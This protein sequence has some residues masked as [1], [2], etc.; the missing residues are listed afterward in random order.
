MVQKPRVLVIEDDE[1]IREILVDLLQ[2][3][4]YQSTGAVHGRD[5]LDK[6]R[7]MSARPKLI[8]LDLM[9]PIMD[10]RE[11][12]EK[13]LA[14]P[15]LADIPVVIISAFRDGER[16]FEALKP[17]AFVPKPIDLQ[18]LLQIVESFAKAG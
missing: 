18:R 13:Q 3:Y 4:G 1:D 14:T 10:G 8:L 15:E 5:A 6:L 7:D 11:F 9:M 16:L 12:R 2:D 17:T